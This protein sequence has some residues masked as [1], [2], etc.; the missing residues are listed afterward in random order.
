MTPYQC[1]LQ[2][3]VQVETIGDFGAIFI[4][5]MAGLE[6]SPEKLKK[7]CFDPDL[8]YHNDFYSQM[9]RPSVH[10]SAV[11]LLS[12]TLITIAVGVPMGL[13]VRQSIFVAACLS[14]CSAP[15]VHQFL[16]GKQ[17]MTR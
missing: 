16:E 10:G 1:S 11:L 12:C 14:L 5:F 2:S 3:V 6:L 9:W 15:L 17:I 7:V 8:A 4:V 13:G